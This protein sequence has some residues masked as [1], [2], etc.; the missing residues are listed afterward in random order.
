MKDTGPPPP[1]RGLGDVLQRREKIRRLVGIGKRVGYAAF[2]LAMVL[3]F[4]A[5]G[6]GFPPLM[7]LA[8]GLLLLV[9][10]IALPP[11]IVFGYGI[12]AAEREE[13]AAA[14]RAEL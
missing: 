11:A 13:R 6:L 7:A 8:L 2:G 5:F 14:H 9:G 1:S 4:V 10:C 12:K 3:F